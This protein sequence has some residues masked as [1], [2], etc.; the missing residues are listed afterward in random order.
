MTEQ[1][2][3]KKIDRLME[4]WKKEIRSIPDV[5]N[6]PKNGARLDNGDGGEYT[7]ITEKYRKLINEIKNK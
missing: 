4:E 6:Q 3:N 5:S 1:E 7:K 2:K